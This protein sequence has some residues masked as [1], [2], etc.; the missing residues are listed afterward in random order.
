MTF[1]NF[2]A[3]NIVLITKKG[4]KLIIPKQGE[5]RVNT[6]IEELGEIEGV[7]VIRKRFTKIPDEQIE[8]I[9]EAAKKGIIIVSRLAGESL[10]KDGRLSEEEKRKIFIIGNSVKDEKGNTVGADALT[11]ILDL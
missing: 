9:K 2:T 1:Y 5:I 4:E 8:Q 7:R 10:K 11:C 6:S 3:H